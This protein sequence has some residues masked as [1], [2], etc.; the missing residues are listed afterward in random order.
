[1]AGKAVTTGGLERIV[2][3][4]TYHRYVKMTTSTGTV[5]LTSAQ[6]WQLSDLLAHAAKE[7]E[8]EST[9]GVI[10]HNTLWV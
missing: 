2:N 4:G 9:E 10:D 1:M 6:A 3:V 8:I 5:L 7:V